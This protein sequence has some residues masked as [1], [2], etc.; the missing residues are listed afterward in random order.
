M[1]LRIL[2]FLHGTAIM[3]KNAVGHTR[4][5]IAKQVVENEESVHD[6]ASY[7]PVG[8]AV[9]KLHEWKKKGAKICY[10]S[11]HENARDMKK[12]KTVLRKYDF[13]SGRIFYRRDGEQY[14][15]VIERINPLPNILIEDDCKSIGGEVEMTYPNLKPKLK[16]R[17]KSIVIKEFEGIDHLPDNIN[18]L[19][20][21]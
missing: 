10:L 14:K 19:L 2:V 1:I 3:H 5:E 9:K 12:D 17:I 11:S 21:V 20:R 4:E 16:A 8:N 18:N 7:V 6:Y 13:P 15:D